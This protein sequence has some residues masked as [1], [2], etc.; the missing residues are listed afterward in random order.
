MPWGGELSG[1]KPGVA[2]LLEALPPLAGG[3]CGAAEPVGIFS[4]CGKKI[5]GRVS[6]VVRANLWLG[7]RLSDWTSKAHFGLPVWT[8]W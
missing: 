2:R 1:E 5:G 6:M 4:C 3:G 7:R 8:V